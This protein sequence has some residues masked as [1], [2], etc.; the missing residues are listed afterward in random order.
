MRIPSK[1]RNSVIVGK[2][3]SHTASRVGHAHFWERAF[4]R[5]AFMG[6]SAAAGA[7]LGSRLL[8]PKLAF[9][10]VEE[11]DPRPIP[12]GLAL[13]SPAAPTIF[14]LFLPGNGTEPSTITDFRGEVAIAEITGTGTGR[15]T[16]TGRTTKLY[17]DCDT[18]F[19][20]GDYIG[21]DGAEHGSTFTFA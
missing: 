10:N 21:L 20:R 2:S 19:M 8:L 14:H 5:R 3:F 15:D 13:L 1:Y 12:G 17:F 6:T 7:L 4:S 9:A 16:R 18:R 11:A